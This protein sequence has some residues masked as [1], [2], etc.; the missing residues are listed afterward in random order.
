MLPKLEELLSQKK[1]R[2]FKFKNQDSETIP[3]YAHLAP[4]IFVFCKN[5]NKKE[6]FETLTQSNLGNDREWIDDNR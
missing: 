5:K 6:I 4:P 2:S 1:I 3:K